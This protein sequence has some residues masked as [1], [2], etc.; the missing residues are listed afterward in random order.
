M[1]FAITKVQK[2]RIQSNLVGIPI[3]LLDNMRLARERANG[4]NDKNI[5]KNNRP[6]PAYSFRRSEDVVQDM[7]EKALMK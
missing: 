1:S 3:L 7:V 4:A 5:D 2:N 6:A